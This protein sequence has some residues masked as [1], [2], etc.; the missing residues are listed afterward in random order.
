[1]AYLTGS[2]R[3]Q[4]VQGMFSRIAHRYDLMNRL[5]TA[6]QDVRWR[7]EVIQR[8]ELPENGYLLDLG[9]GTGNLAMEAQRQYPHCHPV[10]ADFTLE[11]MR[12][13]I[14]R[15]QPSRIEWTAADVL[16]LPYP[17]D[18]FNAVVSGFLLRNVSNVQQSLEEQ[19]YVLKPGGRIVSLDTTPPHQNL[20]TPLI[21]L[22]LNTVIP[23]LGQL[24]TGHR[25]AYDYLPESTESFLGAEQLAGRLIDAGFRN[26]GFRRL[27][28]CT[29]AIHWGTK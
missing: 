6:G 24:I 28:F 26:V 16:Q 14:M 27:M 29:V 8:T 11:M 23:A 10:T 20:L 19:Y 25:D 7:R 3:A 17:A 2:E 18:T 22:H 9:A 4:Y 12:V 15:H 13:G 5:M 21:N 1:M